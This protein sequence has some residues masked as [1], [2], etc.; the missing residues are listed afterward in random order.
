MADQLVELTGITK[1]FPGVKALE[2]ISLDLYAGEVHAL[3]GE[4]GAGKSTLMKIL[5]GVYQ[6]DAGTIRV[7]GQEVE[8]AS[9]KAAEALGIVIIHQELN[10]C[11]HLT[12]AENIFLGREFR[13]RGILDKKRQYEESRKILGDLNID[14]DPNTIVGS[15][16]VSKQ[17]MVE[18]A[19][20]ISVNADI[21]IMD[22]PTSALTEKEIKDL[23]HIIRLL[24]SQGKGII[25]ISHRLEELSNI[26]DRV[27][28]LRD[29]QFVDAMR[30]SSPEEIQGNL[31]G[32]IAKM[33][34]RD[35]KDKYPR[36]D[37]PLGDVVFEA[38]D[39]CTLTGVKH[40]SFQLR[41]GEIVAMAG[42]MGAKRTELVRAIFGADRKTSGVLRIAGKEI[43]VNMPRDAIANG[44]FSVPEDRR[45]DGLCIKMELYKNITL[46]NLDLSS[47]RGVLDHRQELELSS[48][49]VETLRIKTPSLTQLVK[50]LS[51]GNQQKVVLAK[52]LLRQANVVLFDEPTRG[53]DV[54]AKI[55]IYHLMNDLKKQGIGVM[56]V[57]S[58]LPEVLGVSDRILVM[59]DGRITADLKTSETTQ[60]E[61]LH[62][63]TQ[64]KGD[65]A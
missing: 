59:C 27:T 62:Y 4:N 31:E 13:N 8:I 11:K 43:V 15:I 56:Y 65:I 7:K 52:W 36:T 12:V 5:S 17:Q 50:N 3:L 39:I 33:V 49:I 29:G 57:S 35:I 20:A 40:V 60:E 38:K 1:S 21:I 16:A 46:P 24:K 10:L 22:E 28:I 63:A 34:G 2:N 44:I 53:I 32:I 55:E 18:I 9:P 48:R 37:A 64:F 25:Y 14:L 51:G 23:F 26:A 61:I 41:R 19:K 45:R 6:R 54:G 42:L 47:K 30:F 58:E